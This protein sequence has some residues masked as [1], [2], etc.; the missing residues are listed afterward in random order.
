[1]E[2]QIPVLQWFLKA[3]GFQYEET[4][5]IFKALHSIVFLD[6]L[7]H[8]S[9][10]VGEGQH[11]LKSG[12]KVLWIIASTFGRLTLGQTRCYMLSTHFTCSSAYKAVE[13]FPV[14]R[15]K[16]RDLVRVQD[17]LWSKSLGLTRRGSDSLA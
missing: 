4:S 16:N 9:A 8:C 14:S 10:F 7:G 15:Y 11:E 2:L 3:S 6:G 17:S 1:M 12:W 13:L 5:V